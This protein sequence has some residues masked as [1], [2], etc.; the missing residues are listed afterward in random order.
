[1]KATLCVSIWVIG[2]NLPAV[3]WPTLVMGL[4]YLGFMMSYKDRLSNKHKAL[5]VLGT[6]ERLMGWA[7]DHLT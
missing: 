3:A 2:Y 1:M 7:A 6:S 5:I 4:M